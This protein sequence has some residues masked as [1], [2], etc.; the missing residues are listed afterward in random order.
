MSPDE[1][2]FLYEIDSKIEGFGYHSDPR[3]KELRDARDPEA[4]MPVVFECKP[5]QITKNANAIDK[6]TVAYVGPLEPG[7]FQKIN[8]FSI[9]H[10][11]L[12]FPE[13]PVLRQTIE[14]GGKTKEELLD[15][16]KAKGV[17]VSDFAKAMMEHADFVAS[18]EAQ[19]MDFIRLSVA[20]LNIQGTPTTDAV[21]ARAQ[22][23]GLELVPPDAGPAYR[24]ATLDQT[25]EDWVYMGMEQ[26][27]DP[28]GGPSVF[29]VGRNEGGL[30]LGCGWARPGSE[31]DS[32][33]VF[34]FRL[35]KSES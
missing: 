1:L 25:M 26:I 7:I 28:D 2:R 15:E 12:D 23:L 3:I 33:L 31:W 5:E 9:E 19:N 21:Y 18:P 22:E 17:N 30:W 8:E 35:R 24:L 11:Y 16:L 14:I 20:D 27:T 32:G 4:D 34:V 6:N 10:I 13:R 29:N